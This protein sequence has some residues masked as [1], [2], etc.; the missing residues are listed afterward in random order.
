MLDAI[1]YPNV[2]LYPYLV[3]FLMKIQDYVKGA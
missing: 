2:S 1:I 3:S